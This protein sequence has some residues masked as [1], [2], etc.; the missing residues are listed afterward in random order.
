MLIILIVVVALVVLLL[1]VA[2]MKPDSFRVERRTSIEAPPETIFPLINDFHNW[3]AWSPWEKLDPAMKRSYSGPQ[4]GNGAGYGWE[5]NSKAGAGR[6]EITE[7][8]PSSH[9]LIKL[10]FLKPFEAHNTTEYTLERSG[11]TTSVTW[12]MY[13]P[14]QFI[15]KVMQVFMSMDKMVGKDFEA[16]LAN[17][18]RLAESAK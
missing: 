6:M 8:T 4:S 17:M 2:A 12:A 13:G 1:G 3:A 10:D 16:G 11:D 14:N 18:K 9:I 7:S 15:A 5:G